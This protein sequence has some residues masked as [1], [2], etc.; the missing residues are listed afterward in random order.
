MEWV[1]VV[2]AGEPTNLELESEANTERPEPTM[3][4]EG[5]STAFELFCV[6]VEVIG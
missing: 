5:S 1:V 6:S 4:L 3:V 2:I